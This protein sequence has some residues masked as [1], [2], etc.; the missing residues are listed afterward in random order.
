[1]LSDNIEDRNMRP[2]GV[3][4]VRE[5]IAKT[6]AK[7]KERAGGFPSHA[8]VPVGSC[9]N[10]AFEKTENATHFRPLV[11]RRDDV[12]FRSARVCKAGIDSSGNQRSNQA[13]RSVHLF[14]ASESLPR[15]P[16]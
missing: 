14:I 2:A 8:R 4:Q 11:K 6:R 7:M 10:N 13:F 1:M 9:R 12:H 3:V 5:A 16:L 15:I